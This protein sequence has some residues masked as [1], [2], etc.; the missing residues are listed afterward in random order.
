MHY[1]C[2]LAIADRELFPGLY[3]IVAAAKLIAGDA[4]AYEVY[5]RALTYP[6]SPDNE[7][8]VRIR[9]MKVSGFV[10]IE[11]DLVQSFLD[12]S[13]FS[14]YDYDFLPLE[15][16]RVIRIKRIL[17]GWKSGVDILEENRK[18]KPGRWYSRW[19]RTRESQQ[20]ERDFL[21]YVT[22]RFT[23]RENLDNEY[24]VHEYTCG[25]GE[26]FDIRE[27]IRQ[28]HT[29]RIYVRES[30]PVNTAAYIF[31]YRKVHPVSPPRRVK[32]GNLVLTESSSYHDHVFM[33]RYFPWI[34]VTRCS[35]KHYTCGVMTAFG[36][37]DLSPTRIF[38]KID[39]SAPLA[40]SV[41]VALDYTKN[42]FVFTDSPEEVKVPAGTQGRVKVYPCDIIPPP[43]YNLMSGFDIT[44]PR[45]DDRPGD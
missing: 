15:E 4:Y 6:P 28:S 8:E 13:L 17:F 16:G 35:G 31:D 23:A 19:F 11:T 30:A 10:P 3:N 45:Y 33:D 42:V 22:A 39:S 5:Q 36:K 37:L 44:G 18:V 9:K 1:A 21:R 43:V 34:G 20:A 41:K 32:I 26:G 27:T 12:P 14:I 29:G 24:T 38:T 25:F 2:R 7:A 40:S